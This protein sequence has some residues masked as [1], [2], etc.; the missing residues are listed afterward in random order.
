LYNRLKNEPF[1][2]FS[3]S[4]QLIQKAEQKTGVNG[5]IHVKHLPSSSSIWYTGNDNLQGNLEYNQTTRLETQEWSIKWDKVVMNQI[6]FTKGNDLRQWLHINAS[7]IDRFGWHDPSQ[8]INNSHDPNKKYVFYRNDNTAEQWTSSPYI[9]DRQTP[10]AVASSTPYMIYQEQG[11]GYGFTGSYTWPGNGFHL[12]ENV[13]YDVFVRSS[14][15]TESYLPAPIPVGIDNKYFAF[16]HDGSINENT[17]FSLNFPENT[18]CD[19]LIV[20]GGG[21]GGYDRAGGGGAGGLLL[22][23]KRTIN[24]GIYTIKVGKGGV[25]QVTGGFNGLG[26]KGN[27]SEIFKTDNITN[28]IVAEGGGGGGV[29]GVDVRSGDEAIAGNRSIGGGGADAEVS[30]GVNRECRHCGGGEGERA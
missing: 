29:V 14:T 4:Q 15:S 11:T 23:V 26:R 17:T 1:V 22:Y 5:W 25:C 24:A 21:G 19:I 16:K 20:G 18:S 13:G 30:V 10:Y 9:F 28:K 8:A 27:D 7:D 6:L 12:P 2:S 3:Y